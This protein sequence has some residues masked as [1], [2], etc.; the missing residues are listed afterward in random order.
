M[1]SEGYQ[2]VVF[3]GSEA[4][5]KLASHLAAQFDGQV[6]PFVTVAQAASVI[7]R[8]ALVVGL[9]TGFTHMAAALERPTI[10]IYC[11]FDP[12]L[13]GV[14]GKAFT[15]SFGGV[16]KYPPLAEIQHAITLAIRS[17]QWR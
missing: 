9:D 4:E 7:A 6:P 2:V 13:A 5:K 1:R 3:W 12:Q 17:D 15:A 16:G 11:D 14:M 8:A 10:G